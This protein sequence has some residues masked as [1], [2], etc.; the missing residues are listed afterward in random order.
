MT[1]LRSALIHRAHQHRASLALLATAAALMALPDLAQAQA[2][3]D[4]NGKAAA[5]SAWLI[6][7]GLA[8]LTAA[9]AYTGVKVLGRGVQF[10]EVAKLFWAGIFIGGAAIVAAFFFG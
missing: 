2:L 9:T 5:F 8:I 3:P 1:R 10:E 7:S 6:G 4:I